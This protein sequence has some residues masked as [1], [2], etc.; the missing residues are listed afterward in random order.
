MIDA[1]TI[2]AISTQVESIGLSGQSIAVEITEG[3]LLDT[4]SSVTD[5]LLQF[6]D[7]GMQVSLDDFGTG[8]SSLSYLKRLPLDQLKIDQ[9]FV[10]N[11]ML[12]LNDQAIAK[13]VIVLAESLGLEVLAEGVETPA[14]QAFL[15]SLGCHRYQGYLFSEALSIEDFER[16]LQAT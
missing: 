7:R 11:I 15:A 5:Q 3:L 4:S 6:R 8:Y 10:H 12:D 9:G 2:E 16:L 14:Q 1:A 13:M